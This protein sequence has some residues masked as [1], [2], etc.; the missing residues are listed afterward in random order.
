MKIFN[1]LLLSLIPQLIYAQQ[2]HPHKANYSLAAKFSASNTRNLVYSTSVMPQWLKKSNRFWYT[3]TT[4]EG[5]RWYI[6]N[7][8][9]KEKQEMFD[10]DKMAADLTTILKKPYDAQS[11]PDLYLHFTDNED[12]FRFAMLGKE[13]KILNL[14]YNFQHKKTRLL[15]NKVLQPTRRYKPG[16]ASVSPDGNTVVFARGYNLYAVNKQ[17]FEKLTVNFRDTTVKEKQLTTDGIKDFGYG[18][19]ETGAED[20]FNRSAVTV[21]WSPDSKYFAV[22]KLDSR[23]VKELWTINSLAMPRPSLHTY[24]FQMPGDTG[25]YQR[26][27]VLYDLA[28]S[29]QKVLRFNLT[30]DQSVSLWE[31][32]NW[33]ARV[34]KG[35]FSSSVWIGN[36]KKFYFTRI[37]RDL[38]GVDVMEVD[39]QTGNV[40][41]IIAESMHTYLETQS[42]AL[43]NN[44]KELI[45]W[46]ERDGWGHFYL[47]HSNGTL[48]NR[49]TAGPWHCNDIV[50]IDERKRILYFTANGRE[51]GEDPYYK[52]FYKVNFDGTGLKLLNPGNFDHRISPNKQMTYFVDNFS[53]VNTAPVSTLYDINGKK[54]LELEKA[55]LSTLFAHGYKFPEIFKVK[56]AD[57]ITDLYGVIYKPF[58]FDSTKTYPVV[59][60]VYPGPQKEAVQKSFVMPSDMID[61]LA[62]IGLIVVTVGNRGG[63]PERS[64]H[65][66]NFGY[67]NIR[68]YGLADK[69]AALEQIG[70]SRPYID[71][72]RIGIHGHSAGGAMSASAILTYPNFYKV[73]IS[74]SGNHDNTIYNRWWNEKY[75]GRKLQ[76]NKQGDTTYTYTVHKNAELAKNLKGRLLLTTGEADDNVHAANTFRMAKALMNANKRFDMHVFPGAGHNYGMM[77]EWFFWRVA[78]YYSQWLLG[79]FSQPINVTELN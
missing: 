41:T 25:G 77:N 58:D 61:R 6:V 55:D 39:V 73:A 23:K 15:N 51:S 40:K 57:G 44:D 31:W 43:V 45:Q 19:A 20:R 56:A 24:K 14:E 5:R 3:Y 4:S 36:N 1:L 21:H 37:T 42:F 18:K 75:N 54:L 33:K 68:D 69:K 38:T 22:V 49:I 48:K 79:D 9:K 50:H 12:G 26:H 65:Y 59:Q 13:D 71:M 28:Q 67:G 16:W 2:N 47:Y 70:A 46:S 60:Y 11:L 52:H 62:Q 76:I 10:R 34:Q 35:E 30:E 64:K 74:S 66:H 78:D 29:K 32:P 7:P 63:S 27:L 72:K 8:E 17:D 53:R